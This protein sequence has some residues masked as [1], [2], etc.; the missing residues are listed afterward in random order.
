MANYTIKWNNLEHSK[1]AEEHFV[2]RLEKIEKFKLVMPDIR[3]EFIYFPKEK[4][5]EVTLNISVPSHGVI[6]SEAKSGDIITSINKVVDR[7]VDQLRRK[8]T[9]IYRGK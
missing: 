3:A 7:T 1:I 5:Y 9:Q 2:K 8:K 4:D 6:R